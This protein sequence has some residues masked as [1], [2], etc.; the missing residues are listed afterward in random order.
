M[1]QPAIRNIEHLNTM[2]SIR[3][4]VDHKQPLFSIAGTI[5]TDPVRAEIAIAFS[6][7]QGDGFSFRIR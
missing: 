6:A 3:R 4:M 2:V 5:K 7:P 1:G